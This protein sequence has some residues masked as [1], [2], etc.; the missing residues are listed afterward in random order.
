MIGVR[1]SGEPALQAPYDT[2]FGPT[3]GAIGEDLKSEGALVYGLPYEAAKVAPFEAPTGQGELEAQVWKYWRLADGSRAQAAE[4]AR[5]LTAWALRFGDSLRGGSE[6]L[7]GDIITR[8]AQCPNQ[9]IVLTGYSQGAWVIRKALD[10]LSHLPNWN[11]IK[12]SISGIGFVADPDHLLAPPELPK[13]L[14]DRTSGVCAPDDPVCNPPFTAAHSERCFPEL[15]ILCSHLRYGTES[16][17]QTEPKT[18]VQAVTDF[19]RKRL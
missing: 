1:G 15:T 4:A 14:E 12:D 17:P 9:K 11:Q 13:G 10:A 18:G 2:N 5:N 19:L 7:Q 3:V 6:Q 8:V 16:T